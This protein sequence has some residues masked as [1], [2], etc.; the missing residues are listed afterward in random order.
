MAVS[1]PHFIMNSRAAI[2]QELQDLKSNLPSNLNEPVFT[3]PDGY[4]AHFAEHMLALVGRTGTQ[5][6]DAE[7][8]E[9]APTLAGLDKKMPLTVP[10]S[11]FES[12]IHDVPVLMRSEDA[13]PSILSERKSMPHYVPDGYFENFPFGMVEMATATQAK[14]TALAPVVPLFSRVRRLAVAASVVA[15]V[16]VGGWLYWNGQTAPPT[17][18]TAPAGNPLKDVSTQELEQF[19]ESTD[20]V[21]NGSHTIANGGTARKLL[22]DVSNKE[23][24]AFLQEVPE[25]YDL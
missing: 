21:Y 2:Q 6:P 9:L 10:E 24:D 16:A 19:I 23:L 12:L 4:F 5:T 11:Y 8:H 25:G 22:R 14:R 17:V 15:A 18:V 20:A 1:K 13:L 7:L 3:V